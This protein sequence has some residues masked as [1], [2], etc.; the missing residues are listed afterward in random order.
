M[1]SDFGVTNLESDEIAR[2]D[3]GE[4]VLKV[5]AVSMRLEMFRRDPPSTAP[6]HREVHL[7]RLTECGRAILQP[8]VRWHQFLRVR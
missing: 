1:I 8:V 6:D 2:H 5:Y 4:F 3:L 7:R